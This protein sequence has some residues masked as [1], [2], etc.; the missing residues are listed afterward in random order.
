MLSSYHQRKHDLLPVSILTQSQQT[1]SKCVSAPRRLT[2]LALAA[3]SLTTSYPSLADSERLIFRW[4]GVPVGEVT[5]SYGHNAGQ[6]TAA[7]VYLRESQSAPTSGEQEKLIE[8]A[9]SDEPLR[10][11]G[12][13]L[14]TSASLEVPLDQSDFLSQPLPGEPYSLAVDLRS[15]GVARWLRSYQARLRQSYAPNGLKAYQSLAI[16]RDTPEVRLISFPKAGLGAPI[17]YGFLDRDGTDPLAVGGAHRF[18]LSPLEALGATLNGAAEGGCFTRIFDVF[19]GKRAYS[20]EVSELAL[21]NG[22]V[23]CPSNAN[24]LD[25]R[26]VS[27]RKVFNEADQKCVSALAET[28]V[29]SESGDCARSSSNL[30]TAAVSRRFQLLARPLIG[31]GTESLRETNLKNHGS[32]Y[33][34]ESLVAADSSVSERKDNLETSNKSRRTFPQERSHAGADHD[35]AQNAGGRVGT[36]WPF[37]RP[38]LAA[39]IWLSVNGSES[40]IRRI[41]VATPVGKITGELSSDAD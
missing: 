30:R 15:H 17:V 18:W 29:E 5:F 22:E 32:E 11:R 28:R 35:D 34:T 40:R 9:G 37:N 25:I 8:R 38:T 39:E 26:D 16:D 20:L 6:R 27:G 4:Y 23:L 31:K 24:S 14:I 12:E 7:Q 2:S 21:S 41:E 3:F 13:R 36:L 10:S 33:L 1:I 19:D